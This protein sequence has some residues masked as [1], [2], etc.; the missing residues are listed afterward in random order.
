MR[1]GFVARCST[2]VQCGIKSSYNVSI[3]L[4]RA[5]NIRSNMTPEQN[6]ILNGKRTQTTIPFYKVT[7]KK[8]LLDRFKWGVSF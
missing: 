1:I 2:G 5:S 7:A 4:W 3:K 6:I 8:A